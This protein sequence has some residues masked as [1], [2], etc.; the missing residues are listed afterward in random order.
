MVLIVNLA[1]SL[2]LVG[3]LNMDLGV[4]CMEA[5]PQVGDNIFFQNSSANLRVYMSI[6]GKSL[7]HCCKLCLV[8]NINYE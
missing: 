8:L 3:I 1:V 5:D 2:C 7:I 6:Y 4:P